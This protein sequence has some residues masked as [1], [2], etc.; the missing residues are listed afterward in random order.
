MHVRHQNA[1]VHVEDAPNQQ[2]LIS[3]TE[4]RSHVASAPC[5]TLW[6][7]RPL[8]VTKGRLIGVRKTGQNVEVA[9]LA[10]GTTSLIWQPANSLLTQSQINRW[11]SSSSFDTK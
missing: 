10:T 11:L 3:K 1:S 7:D 5:T 6:S 2:P 9:L 8:T 4:N